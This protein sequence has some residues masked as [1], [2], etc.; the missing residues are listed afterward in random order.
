MSREKYETIINK[1]TSE[2]YN[3]LRRTCEKNVTNVQTETFNKDQINS[4]KNIEPYK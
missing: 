3:W 4:I 1:K 2:T